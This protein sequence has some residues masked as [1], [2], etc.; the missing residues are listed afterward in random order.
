MLC[1]MESECELTDLF[2]VSKAGWLIA[3]TYYI[4]EGRW[5]RSLASPFTANVDGSWMQE[6]E[7]CNLHTS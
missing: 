7:R 3:V 2:I 5:L 1:T 4:G 6:R